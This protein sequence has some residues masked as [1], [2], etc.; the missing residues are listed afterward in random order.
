MSPAPP[1]PPPAPP[2]PVPLHPQACPPA[3]VRPCPIIPRRRRAPPSAR[4]SA[5]RRRALPRVLL[6][7]PRSCRGVR[8][9]LGG[10]CPPRLVASVGHLP[11][12][13]CPLESVGATRG[14][15]RA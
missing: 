3:R 12:G 6:L 14:P 10:H 1:P 8:R 9:R 13:A 2:P 5:L 4:P 15:Q 11:L 7:A